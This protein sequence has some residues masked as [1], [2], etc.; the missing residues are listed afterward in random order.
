MRHLATLAGLALGT[1]LF[2][3]APASAASF[4]CSRASSPD[5]LTICNNPR[6]SAL[7]S[8]MAG[9]WYA[10]SRIPMMMGSS[11]NRGD[12]QVAWLA[13]RRACGA[14]AAC[15]ESAYNDRI[16]QLEQL[17]AGWMQ[18]NQAIATGGPGGCAG[19]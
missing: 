8:E 5:E 2:I 18:A 12:E 16:A 9:L 11:G 7:D 3:A 15:I 19:E 4:D 6:L 10:Y 17:I 14:N 13:R 1:L